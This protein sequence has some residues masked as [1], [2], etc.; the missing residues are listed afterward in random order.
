MTDIQLIDYG[1]RKRHFWY[2]GDIAVPGNPRHSIDI[3]SGWKMSAVFTKSGRLSAKAR[4]ILTQYAI[5]D[6]EIK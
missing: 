1:F 3:V 6:G 4:T 5:D 2:L